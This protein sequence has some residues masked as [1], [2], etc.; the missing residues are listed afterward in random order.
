MPS[1]PIV[2]N[3]TVEPSLIDV[4]RETIEFRGK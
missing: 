2:A 1:R 3:S 4:R